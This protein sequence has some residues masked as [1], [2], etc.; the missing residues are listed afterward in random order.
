MVG[1]LAATGLPPLGVVLLQ[2]LFSPFFFSKQISDLDD[3]VTEWVFS[4]V[5]DE[6]GI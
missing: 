5:R 3:L 2:Q 1:G 6:C 4:Y